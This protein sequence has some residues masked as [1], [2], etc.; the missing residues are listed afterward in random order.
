[1]CLLIQ[2]H[3]HYLRCANSFQYF[4]N[5]R[6]MV[7]NRGQFICYIS[8]LSVWSLDDPFRLNVLFLKLKIDAQSKQTPIR[9][10]ELYLVT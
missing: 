1:M 9:Q 10:R 3:F 7:I 4:G 6:N 8:R 5:K 2:T